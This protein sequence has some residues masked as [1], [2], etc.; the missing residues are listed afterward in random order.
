MRILVVYPYA[1]YPI[2]R[3]TFQRTFH[4][5]REL[6]RHNT[7]DFFALDE[8]GASAPHAQVFENFCERVHLQP[9]RHPAWPTMLGSRLVHPTP[10]T[11]RHWHDE[12]AHAALADFTAGQ[13]Y[14]LIH[15][16]DLVMWPYVKRLPHRCPR[17]MDRSRVDLMFQSDELRTLPLSAKEKF[18]RRE[19]LFKLGILERDAARHLDATVV[20]GPDDEIFLRAQVDPNAN[21]FVLP[22]G[23]DPTFFDFAQHPPIPRADPTWLFCGAMD[24]SPNI[25]G[26]GWYFNTVDPEVRAKLPW[27]RVNIVG[28][29]PTAA[30][31]AHANLK[32]V[33][34]TGE[35]PDVRP[36]YQSSM[37]QIVPLRIGGGTRLKIVESLSIGC[38]VIST[39]IGAQGLELRDGEHLLLADTPGEFARAALR[40]VADPT[41]RQRLRTAGRQ[42]V[43][44]LYGWPQLGARLH[45][46]YESL[47]AVTA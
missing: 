32:G 41:L 10:T 8:G 28:K 34:V 17:V 20:C 9:F 31:Q 1:P 38:P 43:L 11:V 15:F 39:T 14:D 18:G 7:V 44:N 37:F 35:V 29:S 24:Y 46:F 22:N 27:R 4:L 47:V 42:Q 16:C 19:N 2:V 36:H 21:I 45:D 12:A 33:T 6:A 3:G 30:V 25:D 40:L 5:L 26:I 23:C 13:E